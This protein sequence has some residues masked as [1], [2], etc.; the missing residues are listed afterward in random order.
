MQTTDSL[1]SPS[2]V[3]W[4]RKDG[5]SPWRPLRKSATHFDAFLWVGVEFANGDWLILPQG[6]GPSH[7]IHADW[8]KYHDFEIP[9]DVTH[10]ETISPPPNAEQ[11]QNRVFTTHFTKTG[12]V[13][14]KSVEQLEEI[15]TTLAV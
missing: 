13:P 3:L 11:L 8:T 7:G 6:S 2:Y 5:K 15:V 9:S 4:F 10:L 12:L 1:T 14:G